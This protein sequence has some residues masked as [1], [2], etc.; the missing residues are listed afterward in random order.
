[1]GNKWCI[2]RKGVIE[3]CVL[4][5]S[6]G[7]GRKQGDYLGG[8]RT[9]SN[10]GFWLGWQGGW[11]YH[12]VVERWLQR[13]EDKRMIEY[14]RKK[15]ST[16]FKASCSEQPEPGQGT[17]LKWK[18]SDGGWG[19]RQPRRAELRSRSPSLVSS[20]AVAGT[21]RGCSLTQNDG[22]KNKEWTD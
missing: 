9:W 5:R 20:E 6:Q 13:L 21:D 12:S 2:S 3:F 17:L 15:Q 14:L 18:S 7:Q 8:T 10:Y 22:G 4:K 16:A 11:V 19:T 1:M